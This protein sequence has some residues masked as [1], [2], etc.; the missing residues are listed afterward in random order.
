[1][2]ARGLTSEMKIS[3][4][5]TAV[6]KHTVTNVPLNG[7]PHLLN[8]NYNTFAEKHAVPLVQMSPTV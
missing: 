2:K 6:L 4:D 7:R 8:T 3:G 1:M 5:M